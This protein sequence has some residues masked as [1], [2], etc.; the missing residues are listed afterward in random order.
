MLLYTPICRTIFL[1][2]VWFSIIGD[3]PFIASDKCT[4]KYAHCIVLCDLCTSG[5]YNSILGQ[6]GGR[7]SENVKFFRGIKEVLLITQ[8]V[9]CPKLFYV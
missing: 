2:I 9:I 6:D 4:Q 3:R 5:L 8:R 1:C 7:N